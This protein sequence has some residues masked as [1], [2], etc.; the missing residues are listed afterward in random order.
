MTP[1][2]GGAASRIRV[3]VVDDSLVVRRLVT[4]ALD[5]DPQIEVVGRGAERPGRAAEDRRAPARRGHDGHRDAG[6]ERHRGGPRGATHRA[7]AARRDVLHAHRAR[8]GRHARRARRRRQRL[9]HQAVERRQLRRQPAE[10][11]RAAHPEAQGAHG[12][13]SR[14][15]SRHVRTRRDPRSGSPGHGG[16]PV[17]PSSP[18]DAPPAVRTRSRPSCRRFRPIFRCRS[19]WS[20]TCPRC[21]PA[22]WPQRLDGQCKAGRRRGHAWGAAR[23]RAR[24]HRARRIPPRGPP[25]RDQR[26]GAAHRGPSGELLPPRGRRPVPFGRPPST[27]SGCWRRSSPGWAATARGAPGSS[28]PPVATCSSRTTPRASC[29]GCRAPSPRAGQADRILPL[30]QIGPRALRGAHAGRTRWR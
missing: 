25:V 18:S 6:D 19:S 20:S 5:S 26:R 11:P 22:S 21:S 16:R 24:A 10:R 12:R 15:W 2:P 4:D 9:R 29:G 7:A 28:A 13:P 27:A 30:P 3:L 17:T 14:G 1:G 23:A 8:R